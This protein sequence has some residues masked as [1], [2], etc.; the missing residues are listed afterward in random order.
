MKTKKKEPD[1]R[2]VFVTG[3]SGAGKTSTLK[4]LEDLGYE[5]IDNLPISLLENLKLPSDGGDDPAERAGALP[6]S[7]DV[8][9]GIDVRTREFDAKR[10]LA[11]IDRFRD[12]PG[13]ETTLLFLECGTDELGNRF[14]ATRRRHPLAL[15]RPVSDGIKQERAV[16]AALKERADL[17]I[18]STGK[19]L[20]DF[21]QEIESH[22]SGAGSPGLA[23][24]VTSF[25]FARGVPRDADLMFDVRF[26][27]NP[28]Y[29]EK[30]RDLSGLDEPVQ[31]FLA[32]DPDF[33]PF[34]DNLIQMLKPL[35][36]RY[37]AEG[38]SYL[39][40]AIGC[41]GG[42][43]RS[44]ATA[45]KL[46]AWLELKRYGPHVTHRDLEKGSE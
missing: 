20:P 19:S 7:R 15:D 2:I 33:V 42:K 45:E 22:F 18:D 39:T 32:N 35:L 30:L 16:V 43:H 12:L 27:N 26:L 29:D 40:I 28:H 23:I 9:V 8:A 13:I 36:P 25:S 46:A 31:K 37:A 10:V 44:V 3:M 21:R 34:F 17:I 24:F 14:K 5:A 11:A 41:T 1:Q 6:H 4:T 38:K